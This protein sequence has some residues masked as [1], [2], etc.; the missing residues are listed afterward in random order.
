M[1]AHEVK[2]RKKWC[3][4]RKSFSGLLVLVCFLTMGNMQAS[5]SEIIVSAAASMTDVLKAVGKAYESANKGARINYN[6]ASS[7]SLAAQ[8]EQGAPVDVY[9][10]VSQPI[11]KRLDKKGLLKKDSMTV[12][13]RNRLVVATAPG[14]KTQI[15]SFADLKKPDITKI[16]IGDVAHVPAG[17]YARESLVKSWLWTQL[18]KKYV[19][20]SDVRQVRAYIMQEEVEVGFVYATDCLVGTEKIVRI[21]YKVPQKLHQ[22]ILYTAA[23]VHDT[24]N[25]KEAHRFVEFLS[26]KEARKVLEKYN[27]EPVE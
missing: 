17:M 4:M 5:A 21:A 16:A 26:S 13:A 15:G 19:F 12:F 9:I 10:S 24:H 2:A 23:V 11:I 25:A 14:S 6:F 1:T 18:E 8:I 22:P 20:A 7:G 27:F 3:V